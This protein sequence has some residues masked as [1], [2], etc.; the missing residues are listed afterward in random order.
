LLYDQDWYDA[1]HEPDY[2]PSSAS[3]VQWN[4]R[5]DGWSAHDD[6]LPLL[7]H[8]DGQF[9]PQL[10]YIADHG[11]INLGMVRLYTRE[12]DNS[13]PTLFSSLEFLKNKNSFFFYD[14]S[15]WVGSLEHP[16]YPEYGRC[17]AEIITTMKHGAFACIANS[18][19]G[20]G[21]EANDLNSPNTHLSREFFDAIFGE[22]IFCLGAAHQDAKEDSLWAIQHSGIRYVIY[23]LNLFGDPALNLQIANDSVY[24][25]PFKPVTTRPRS[26]RKR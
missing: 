9:P 20:W 11:D 16:E 22:G 26:L 8:T 25:S 6:L 18:R 19:Y 3:G 23:N 2:N 21:S 15:C 5:T 13:Y 1:K 4:W 10:I 24:E 14:D 17:F 7:N 12:A